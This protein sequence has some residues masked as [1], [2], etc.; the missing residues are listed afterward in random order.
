MNTQTTVRAP[1]PIEP[2]IALERIS[3]ERVREA[4][5]RLAGVAERT[6]AIRS[7]TLEDAL[8]AAS[9]VLK[10][11]TM[12]AIGAFKIRGAY[13]A[14]SRL[15]DEAKRS[16]VLT[17]SSGNHAQAVALAGRLLGVRTVILMPEN[18]PRVKLD[19]TR[20]RLDPANGSRIEIYGKGTP[21]RE[22]MAREIGAREALTLIPPYDNPDVVC[23]QGTAALELFEDHPD[24]DALFVPVGGGGLISGSATVARALA[25]GCKIVGIEPELGGDAAASFRSGRIEIAG[26]R[27]GETICDGAATPYLGAWTFPVIRAR[28]DDVITATDAEASRAMR[29]MMDKAKLVV[30]PTGALGLAGAIKMRDQI[31]GKKVG[32]IVSGG[33][34][35]I[36]RLPELLAIGRDR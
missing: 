25:P 35:D 31:A 12:Q 18:A 36:D 21:G 2:G 32:V 20:A 3:I 22:D 23:G 28:V 4:A 9:V 8:G 13:N 30:E 19:A 5:A 33:N 27:V 11:E 29:L 6:P 26:P 7:R 16:G 17:Y 10:C 15:S 14:I 34:V 24:L 1:T